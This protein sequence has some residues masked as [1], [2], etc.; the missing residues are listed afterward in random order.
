MSDEESTK[1]CRIKC[2][3]IK[4]CC[5]TGFVISIPFYIL[6]LALSWGF[7][8]GLPQ[9]VHTKGFALGGAI[10]V[11]LPVGLLVIGCFVAIYCSKY[12]NC[13]DTGN[14][15]GLC[16]WASAFVCGGGC[17]LLGGIL[18]LLAAAGSPPPSMF[19]NPQG[20]S[21]FAAIAG[22]MAV[23]AGITYC[24]GL[25]GYA[26]KEQFGDEESTTEG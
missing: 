19:T 14:T 18:L 9:G 20:Y 5:I 16:S 10:V 22:I 15:L 7:A 23:V 24:C 6:A 25:C 17:S 1:D 21:A 4:C 2:G 26:I 8:E 11:T 12:L 13:N 3:R